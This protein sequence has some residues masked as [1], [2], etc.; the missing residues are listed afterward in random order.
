MWSAPPRSHLTEQGQ[1]FA[2]IEEDFPIPGAPSE[3]FCRAGWPS[4]L[5]GAQGIAQVF[6]KL[7]YSPGQCAVPREIVCCCPIVTLFPQNTAEPQPSHHIIRLEP[8]RL[9]VVHRGLLFLPPEA[10]GPLNCLPARPLRTIGSKIAGKPVPLPQTC[11]R[12]AKAFPKL[13]ME[14]TRLGVT[15]N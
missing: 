12:F 14:R 4:L 15:P 7:P 5:T 3:A 10:E 9:P 2:Q 13:T 11:A 8:H 1:G 6:V